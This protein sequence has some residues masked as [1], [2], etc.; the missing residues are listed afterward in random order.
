MIVD[1]FNILSAVIAP[2]EADAELVVDPNAVLAGPVA[3][4]RL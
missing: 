3:T 1:N 2:S 4:K